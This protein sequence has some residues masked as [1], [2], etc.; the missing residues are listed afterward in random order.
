MTVFLAWLSSWSSEA[1]ASATDEV[2]Y[3]TVARRA[4]EANGTEPEGQGK[5]L[6]GS[7]FIRLVARSA[8]V[9]SAESRGRES[10]FF[11]RLTYLSPP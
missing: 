4:L 5:S 11:G 9:D 2:V 8:H 7:L 10:G 1:E 6:P 3:I